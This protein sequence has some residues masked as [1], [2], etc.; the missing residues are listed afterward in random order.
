MCRSVCCVCVCCPPSR[1]WCVAVVSCC[2]AA[3]KCPIKP[4]LRPPVPVCS[5]IVSSNHLSASCPIYCCVLLVQG[6]DFRG[7]AMSFVTHAIATLRPQCFSVSVK[8]LLSFPPLGEGLGKDT[9]GF[10]LHHVGNPL[11][12]TLGKGERCSL[13]VAGR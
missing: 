4:S 5:F 13:I 3:A 8:V 10:T 9:L 6:A 11:L 2:C 7:F 1:C 12:D